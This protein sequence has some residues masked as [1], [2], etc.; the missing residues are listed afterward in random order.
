MTVKAGGGR[1]GE[2]GRRG[3]SPQL[4]EAEV[5]KCVLLS[6]VMFQEVLLIRICTV[7]VQDKW[8]LRNI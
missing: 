8:E 6:R 4:N 5:R 3:V 7:N 2:V 1:L